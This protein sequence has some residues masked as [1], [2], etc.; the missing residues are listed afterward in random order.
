MDSVKASYENLTFDNISDLIYSAAGPQAPP[1]KG[2]KHLKFHEEPSLQIEEVGDD[3]IDQSAHRNKKDFLM[4]NKE[5]Y[6]MSFADPNDQNDQDI[7]VPSNN[8]SVVGGG[9]L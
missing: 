3:S 1:P 2:Q 7:S 5:S 6:I 8:T 4:T 9:G